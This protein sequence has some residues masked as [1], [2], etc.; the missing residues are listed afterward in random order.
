[1]KA[2]RFRTIELAE[3]AKEQ[4]SRGFRSFSDTVR[5]LLGFETVKPFRAELEE[6][7]GRKKEGEKR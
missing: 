6:F 7:L 5:N 2:I 4:R 1:M 3:I